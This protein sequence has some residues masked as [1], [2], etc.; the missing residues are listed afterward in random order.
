[1]SKRA[2]QMWRDYQ[3]LGSLRAVGEKHGITRERVRQI[4]SEGGYHERIGHAARGLRMRKVNY[5]EAVKLYREGWTTHQI[6]EHYGVTTHTVCHVRRRM[7][8]KP[9]PRA[10]KHDYE[11]LRA[12]WDAGMP[13]AGIAAK[14]GITVAHFNTIAHRQAFPLRH[15]PGKKPNGSPRKWEG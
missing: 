8:V 4:L 13:M 3:E 2:E 9:R 12:D 14:H 11:A 5:E 6:A 10:R 1:M 7:G 15:R